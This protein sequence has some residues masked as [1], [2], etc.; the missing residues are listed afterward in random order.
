[1]QL[2]ATGAHNPL[3]DATSDPRPVNRADSVGMWFVDGAHGWPSADQ[4][5]DFA[6]RH[7]PAVVVFPFNVRKERAASV[8][9][10]A[11]RKAT[12][13]QSRPVG[14][15]VFH[16]RFPNAGQTECGWHGLNNP[17]HQH[18]RAGRAFPSQM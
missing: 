16:W 1:M 18:Y 4:L 10:K 9:Q 8:I 5:D 6:V 13:D 17:D 14:K 11:W 12:R 2:C 15:R 3:T 7:L